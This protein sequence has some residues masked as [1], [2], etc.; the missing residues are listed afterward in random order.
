MKYK[1]FYINLNYPFDIESVIVD[2]ESLTTQN[3][4]WYECIGQSAIKAEV[5]SAR[6]MIKY[7]VDEGIKSRNY[8]KTYIDMIEAEDEF[9]E[10][11]I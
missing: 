7:L 10:E 6:K 1:E 3:I 2:T 4:W 8:I 5:E 9:P 11:F